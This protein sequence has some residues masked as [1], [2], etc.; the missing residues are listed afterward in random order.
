ME[1]SFSRAL[2]QLV[3]PIIDATY[4][5][6]DFNIPN[7]NVDAQ[8]SMAITTMCDGIV[9]SLP[10]APAQQFHA[11]GPR[12]LVT[13]FIPLVDCERTGSE[14]W[15]GSHKIAC[16]D[17]MT[18]TVLMNDA[19]RERLHLK[20]ATP[21]LRRGDVLLFDYRVIHRGRRHPSGPDAC[22]RPMMYRTFNWGGDAVG[23]HEGPGGLNWPTERLAGSR[24]Q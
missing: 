3:I 16:A 21:K 24:V 22:E 19:I 5:S 13:A 4:L 11:D 18:A 9:T 14:F 8:P 20:M 15:L 10:G 12:G 23:I 17:F 6:A 2:D 1:D 7:T